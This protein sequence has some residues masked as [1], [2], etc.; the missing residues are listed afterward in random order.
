MKTSVILLSKHRSW[1]VIFITSIISVRSRKYATLSIFPP[2]HMQWVPGCNLLMVSPFLQWSVILSHPRLTTPPL[3]SRAE[4]FC[5]ICWCGSASK[6]CRIVLLLE[7]FF[8][9][10]RRGRSPPPP[11][12]IGCR[13]Q[14]VIIIYTWSTCVGT[15]KG[16]TLRY[17]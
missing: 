5:N 2:S 13:L 7:L 16:T 1:K 12:V 8:F 14:N 3:I 11:N 17:L 9:A 15:K 4:L 10:D 6:C